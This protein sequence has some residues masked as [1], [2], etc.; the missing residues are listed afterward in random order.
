MMTILQD[1]MT[2]LPAPTQFKVAV[3]GKKVAITPMVGA[4]AEGSGAKGDKVPA[5]Q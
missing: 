3:K 1:D 4:A 5:G 2:D